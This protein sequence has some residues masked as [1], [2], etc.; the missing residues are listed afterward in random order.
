M[1][2]QRVRPAAFRTTFILDAS[3]AWSNLLFTKRGHTL[4]YKSWSTPSMVLRTIG[5]PELVD[6]LLDD[7]GQPTRDS[8]LVPAS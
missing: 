2:P 8:D 3:R 1:A 7:V 5:R 4:S 6:V